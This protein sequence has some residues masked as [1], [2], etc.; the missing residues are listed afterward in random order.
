MTCSMFDQGTDSL[1]S[2]DALRERKCSFAKRNVTVQT[3]LV[4]LSGSLEESVLQLRKELPAE[5]V[6]SM[7]QKLVRSPASAIGDLLTRNG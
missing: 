1:P 2:E 5:L 3:N 4:N 6:V 7:F